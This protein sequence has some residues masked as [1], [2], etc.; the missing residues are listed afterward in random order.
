[1]MCNDLGRI[2]AMLQ[3]GREARE[4]FHQQ[5]REEEQRH[6]RASASGHLPSGEIPDVPIEQEIKEEQ[7]AT[8]EPS[9]EVK[10]YQEEL[11]QKKY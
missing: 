10:I 6:E 11:E 5:G 8:Q 1:M 9:E 4:R 2:D 3:S 7:L